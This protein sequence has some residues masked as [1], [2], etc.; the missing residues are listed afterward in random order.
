MEKEQKIYIAGIGAITPV[1]KNAEMTFASVNARINRYQ[2]SGYFTESK[3][4][5]KMAL[6][7]PDALP[8]INETPAI[9]G[10]TRWDRHLLQ[11]AHV[12]MIDAV[13]NAKIEKP[14]PLILACPQH[15]A[16]WPHQ[17]PENFVKCLIEQS[18]VV[19]DPEL[20]RTV[21][22][23]R[24]GI[25][26][27]LQ[28]AFK[29]FLDTDAETILI[30]G[31]DSFQRPELFRGLL[32]EGR[33]AIQDN[34]DG[35]TPG[36]GAGFILLTRNKSNAFKQDK[37]NACPLVRLSNPGVAQENGHMYSEQPCLGDGL[38]NAFKQTLGLLNGSK[39]NHIYSSMNGE[40]F[41]VKEL[42][43]A[44]SRNQSFLSDD[45]QLVHPAD[46]YGDLGAASGAVLMG[47]AAQNLMAQQRKMHHLVCC[48]SDNTYRSA[49]VLAQ[50]TQA[51]SNKPVPQS[52]DTIQQEYT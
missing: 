22:T 35:F 28:I 19:V 16:K 50:E 1:G 31:V 3:Q 15:Y 39:I 47:I 32:E 36:E 25:L 5:V 8:D 4:P 10:Y 30:G 44:I 33:I 7:P 24:A 21:Q 26:D 23:G 48:S 34:F 42:G 13:K 11:M 37:K 51:N 40:R 9:K 14:V 20:S 45:Y 46:C 6:V 27:A 43:A 17:L 52:K 12:A 38:T 29:Y 2:D 49:V 41:W 18:G